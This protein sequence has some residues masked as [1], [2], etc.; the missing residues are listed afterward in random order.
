MLGSPPR[1]QPESS[2]SANFNADGVGVG[3]AVGV[4]VGEGLGVAIAVGVSGTLAGEDEDPIGHRF[5]VA[6][7]STRFAAAG[8]TRSERPFLMAFVTVA[9]R[10]RSAYPLQ[11]VLPTFRILAGVWA[12]SFGMMT[13]ISETNALSRAVVMGTEVDPFAATA[14]FVCP[15]A[16]DGAVTSRETTAM[17]K[18]TRVTG[19]STFDNSFP[20]GVSISSRKTRICGHS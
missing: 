3:V 19:A 11:M 7:A 17:N 9:D 12:F 2:G 16:K 5:L 8:L 14:L 4:A 13:R 15:H 18:V 20:L 1:V 10:P 6:E